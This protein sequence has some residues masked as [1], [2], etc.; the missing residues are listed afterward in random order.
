MSFKIIVGIG[1]L[2]VFQMRHPTVRAV[3]MSEFVTQF[4]F[5]L[6]KEFYMWSLAMIW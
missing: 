4:A 3:Y 6:R 1:I 2:A 5:A